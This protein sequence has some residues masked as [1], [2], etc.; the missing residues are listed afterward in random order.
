MQNQDTGRGPQRPPS[1]GMSSPSGPM[2]LEM[3]YGNYHMTPEMMQ[4]C[5]PT[6]IGTIKPI[7]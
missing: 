3:A 2:P 1:G 4:V 7:V 5:L 6:R